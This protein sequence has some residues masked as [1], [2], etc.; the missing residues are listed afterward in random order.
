M[1]FRSETAGD[2]SNAD[3]RVYPV[4]RIAGRFIEAIRSG[5]TASPNLENGL[6]VQVLLDALRLA[7]RSGSWQAVGAG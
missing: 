5:G 1:L 4:S 7:D 2:D 6:R 3:G